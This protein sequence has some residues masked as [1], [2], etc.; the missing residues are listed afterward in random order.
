MISRCDM[1]RVLFWL[2]TTLYPT[3]PV[4][5]LIQDTMRYDVQP[6][7]C[8]KQQKKNPVSPGEGPKSSYVKM[9]CTEEKAI[10]IEEKATDIEGKPIEIEE[11]KKKAIGIEEKATGIEENSTEIEEKSTKNK[12][13]AI[14]VDQNVQRSVTCLDVGALKAPKRRFNEKLDLSGI[15]NFGSGRR[16][17]AP[18]LSL[19]DK[20]QRP[21]LQK[22]MPEFTHFSGPP[23]ASQPAPAKYP[24]E[25]T[26]PGCSIKW[27]S[28]IRSKYS[29]LQ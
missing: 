17:K 10:G 15:S 4:P 14:E 11:K 9:V 7:S 3:P 2:H 16:L 8:L 1:N 20:K 28:T 6:Q 5:V 26:V 13:K 21:G 19:A 24:V 25:P 22:Q 23:L 29:L 27:A 12:E 18:R